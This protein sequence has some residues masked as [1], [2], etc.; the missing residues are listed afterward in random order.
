[1][2]Y[3][4]AVAIIVTLTAGGG[5]GFKAGFWLADQKNQKLALANE[6]GRL[7][8]KTL[9]FTWNAPMQMQVLASALPEKVLKGGK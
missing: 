3:L 2:K 7:D 8:P 4:V 6:C 9:E 5:A 1:M